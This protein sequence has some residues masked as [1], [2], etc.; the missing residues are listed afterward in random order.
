MGLL[1]QA[2]ADPP[3]AAS[4]ESNA[5]AT[6]LDNLGDAV[7]ATTYF[8]GCSNGRIH[9]TV[10]TTA[11]ALNVVRAMRPT[12]LEPRAFEQCSASDNSRGEKPYTRYRSISIFITSCSFLLYSYLKPFILKVLPFS[13][14]LTVGHKAVVPAV[15]AYHPGRANTS[16]YGRAARITRA[17]F[18]SLTIEAGSRLFVKH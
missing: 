7:P 6:F 5:E 15:L 8:T 2:P 18:L 11:T 14:F 13:P 3:A 17:D 4:A 10:E 1:L 16:R 12:V 9:R